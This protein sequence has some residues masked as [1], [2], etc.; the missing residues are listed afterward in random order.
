MK[1]RKLLINFKC[2]NKNYCGNKLI[3]NKRIK[4]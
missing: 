1:K 4:L 2:D 3:N